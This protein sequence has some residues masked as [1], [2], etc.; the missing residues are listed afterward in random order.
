MT[1]MSLR[2]R[3]TPCG[4]VV[5]A[6]AAARA[7]EGLRAA[8]ERDGWVEALDG[9]W[10]ALAPV[11]AASSYLAGLV[12]RRPA[13]LQAILAEDPQAR[14]EAILADAGAAGQ[15]PLPEAGTALRRGKAQVHLLTALC[16][17]GGV[18]DLDQ[19]TGALTR[20]AD[21]SLSAALA[22][23]V[24]AEVKAGR[25]TLEPDAVLPGY[26]CIAM[27]KHGA[28]EL[29][30]SSDIDYSVFY[31]PALLPLAEGIEP[32]AFAIRLTQTV[33]QT[34]QDRTA[35]GYVFRVDLRL[36]PD[37]SSTPIAVTVGAAED[38]YQT[39]GQNWE[40]AAFI[41]A[42]ACAGDLEAGRAF[43]ADLQP[44][45]WRRNLDFAAIEDIHSIKRQIH[46][47]KVD[48]SLDPRG[49]DLKLGR[50]GIREVEFFV[51]TQQ[52]ILGGRDPSLRSIRTVDALAA[53]AA[54]GH[55]TPQTAEDLT[56]SYKTL[57][58]LEHRAQMIA[59]HQTHKLP[60]DDAE[61]TAIAALAG[62]RSL[63]A[64][65]ADVG[66]LLTRVNRRYGEL[67]AEDEDLSSRFG[68]L[69]FT[70]VEDDPETLATLK[71]MGFSNPPQVAETIRA[72]HHGRINATRSAR[73]RELFTRLAPRFLEAAQASGAPDAAFTRF[74]VFFAGLSAGV[75]VQSLF[76][77]QPK[78][79]QLVVDV[80][81]YAPNLA[82]TLAKRPAA[83]DALLDRLFFG[84]LDPAEIEAS[85]L[86]A[87]AR[88]DGFEAV[89]DAA[90]RAHREQT[91]RIGVQLIGG[92]A[93]AAEAG[94]AFTAVADA[95]LKALGPAALAETSRVGGVFE[96]DVAILALGKCGSGEM[97]ATS[98]LDL[99]I[100]YGGHAE[101][102]TSAGKGWWAETFWGRF[103]QRLVAALSSPTAEGGLYEVDLKLRPFGADGAVAVSTAAFAD[104]Y[105]KHA[106]TW[107]LLALTRGRV[108][109]TSREAFGHQ[110]QGLVEAA[111]RAP[112]DRA[113]AAVDTRAM[114]RLMDEERPAKGLWDLKLSPGGLVDIEFAAQFLQIVSAETGG[115]LVLHTGTAL[116]A[117]L[118]LADPDD[119]ATLQ[120][121]WTLQQDLSQVLK[122]ALPDGT[123]PSEE[124]AGF[125]A[126][127]ARAGGARDFRTLTSRLKVAR[128]AARKAYEA[129]VNG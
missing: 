104:Y 80:L 71:R 45:I 36:R 55:I 38:Y 44:F 21:A 88:A 2:P 73:G 113:Q 94:P 33:A 58:T 70:G 90:R 85:V 87:C 127:L 32:H 51:Q 111:L 13:D 118:G 129:V 128:I 98:D 120:T 106:E 89:M 116:A 15:S 82:A 34:M 119:L 99:I 27:G 107:E 78:L 76:L 64:F 29:N 50:G 102:A 6:A 12:R 95:C 26:F 75:Q 101:G 79:L 30:Y 56:A 59:D 68:S 43:L 41:K 108:A 11:F 37:P 1:A 48:D 35:D 5:N 122:V 121:A 63:K 81:A 42:R 54:A 39:V 60:K 49:A 17:L 31:E 103:T 47:H 72:W 28:H 124:P 117:C 93:H 10:P 67:F 96:G 57:R 114:R 83:L 18:W 123:D 109:W 3:L 61:R 16:D 126:L 92:T 4:P 84:P 112:R 24:H 62:Y 23:A 69:V 115:P 7:L 97:T 65:D 53:L 8:A 74:S 66:K 77:A 9:A 22:A 19:V 20:F 110:V 86:A 105:A 100:V 91:F 52:L 40:R 46:V 25:L 125:R 14:L